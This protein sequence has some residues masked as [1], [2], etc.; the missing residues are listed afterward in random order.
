MISE[1]LCHHCKEEGEEGCPRA[2]AEEK[3]LSLK[4]KETAPSASSNNRYMTARQVY[5]E[6]GTYATWNPHGFTFEKWLQERLNCS[7]TSH[8]GQP[9][10]AS[11]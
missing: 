3:L 6:W 8:S 4:R 10:Y 5:E 11:L 9:L 7:A 2:D 1:C